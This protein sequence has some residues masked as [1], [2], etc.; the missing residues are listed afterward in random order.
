MQ[1]NKDCIEYAKSLNPFVYGFIR[2]TLMVIDNYLREDEGEKIM[3]IDDIK[4]FPCF[5][6]HL[7]KVEKLEQKE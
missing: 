4:I 5:D 7:P 1:W 2:K 6:A 3:K